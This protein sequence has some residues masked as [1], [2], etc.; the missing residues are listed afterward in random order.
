MQ[1]CNT[2]GGTGK[3]DVREDTPSNLYNK[4][5]DIQE[6]K[7]RMKNTTIL[8]QDYKAVVKKYDSSETV[9]YLD[10]PY[11]NSDKLYKHD[12]MNYE[13]MANLLRS[14]KGKFIL[15]INDSSNIRTI[16]KCFKMK[17]TT[18]IT[19]GNKGIGSGGNRSELLIMNY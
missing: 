14:I 17:T 15:S 3:G 13:Q 16:F 5:K 7:D 2:F 9:F 6:Y 12:S 4:L 10:P 19:Q 8:S 1:T 11:E 18:V